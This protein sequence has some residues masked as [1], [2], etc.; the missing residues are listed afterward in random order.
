VNTVRLA[1]LLL[2]C[3]C[4]TLPDTPPR[5][6][7]GDLLLGASLQRAV[8]A[9]ATLF[10]YHFQPDG[11]ELNDLGRRDLDV[12]TAHFLRATGALA[13][14]RG[15]EAAELHEARVRSVLAALEAGGVPRDRVAVRDGLPG[16]D[17][18]AS[19]RIVEVLRRPLTL[20][21]AGVSEGGLGGSSSGSL[22]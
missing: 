4:S 2:L 16:G 10:P 18:A 8:V 6:G 20:S 7:T 17:G 11:A 5:S 19:S 12:L 13:I 1:A 3:A 21:G 14:R 9:Q 15:P 22:P